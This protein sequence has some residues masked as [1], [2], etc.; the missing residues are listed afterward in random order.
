MDADRVMAQVRKLIRDAIKEARASEIQ[1]LIESLEEYLEEL[2]IVADD[3]R[4]DE[5]GGDIE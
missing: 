1:R 2:E 4:C 5:T 3:V